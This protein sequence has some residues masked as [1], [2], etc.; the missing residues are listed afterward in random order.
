MLNLSCPMRRRRMRNDPMRLWQRREAYQVQTFLS[1]LLG[2]ALMAGPLMQLLAGHLAGAC[3][4]LAYEVVLLRVVRWGGRRLLRWIGRGSLLLLVALGSSGCALWFQQT[5]PPIQRTLLV[6]E[7]PDV[8]FTRALLV[9]H[10]LGC[11]IWGQDR[12]ARTVQAFFRT[13]TQLTVTV[14]PKARGSELQVV[15]QNLPSYFGQGSDGALSD[16][17]LARYAQ[18]LAAKER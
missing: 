1:G 3:F 4:L 11:T 17:F 10:A 5:H 13:E 9:L 12:Q 16:I 15:H 18:S 7:A 8:A 14:Q 6:P 2:L